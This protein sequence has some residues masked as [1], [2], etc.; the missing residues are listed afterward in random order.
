MEPTKMT[1]E[2]IAHFFKELES[3]NKKLTEWEENFIISIKDQY[4]HKSYLTQ[5][6]FVILEKIYAEKT[7]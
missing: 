2:I 3:P 1:P 7:A 6:Q 5:K 4:D